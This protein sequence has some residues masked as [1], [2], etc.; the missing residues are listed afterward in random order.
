MRKFI[1][2]IVPTN[3]LVHSSD[4]LT[5]FDCKLDELKLDIKLLS[6]KR[7]KAIP[8]EEET[9]T[10]QFFPSGTGQ[11]LVSSTCLVGEIGNTKMFS[12]YFYILAE[13]N[14]TASLFVHSCAPL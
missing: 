13:N 3:I 6:F 9:Y 12:S 1:T 11:G 10:F 2:S 4:Q 7:W 8:V 5:C 14:D